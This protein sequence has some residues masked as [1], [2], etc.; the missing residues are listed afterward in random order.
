MAQ[1]LLRKISPATVFAGTLAIPDNQE[2]L[3]LYTLVGRTTSIKTGQ[4]NKDMGE[5]C[6][7]LGDFCAVTEKGD[8]FRSAACFLPEPVSGLIRSRIE[9]A[10]KGGGK[11]EVEFA[12]NISI[13]RSKRDAKKYEYRV[14]N[15]MEE[16][17]SAADPLAGLLE[18]AG[19]K[20]IPEP[21]KS[22]GKK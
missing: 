22:K 17:P 7:F 19:R 5:W 10:T 3:F 13:I 16:D 12:Y 21:E 1:N 15:L 9:A 20:A 8:R 2:S 18:S 4:N 14:E 11:A 6:K